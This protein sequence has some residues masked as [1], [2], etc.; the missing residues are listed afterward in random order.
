MPNMTGAEYLA[1]MLA[2]HGVGHVFMVPAV[3]RRTF[4]EMERRTSI[5]RIHTRP[6]ISILSAAVLTAT[7]VHAALAQSKKGGQPGCFE[8]CIKKG[9]P[10]QKCSKNCR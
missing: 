1:D 8:R 3:L 6:L 7:F 9:I 4:A 2:G 10:A 5:K